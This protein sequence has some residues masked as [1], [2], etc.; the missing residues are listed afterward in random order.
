MART[1]K[2]PRKER[3]GRTV[4]HTWGEQAC[5]VREARQEGRRSE[6]VRRQRQLARQARKEKVE[7]K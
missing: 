3:E 5:L 7:E 6:E 4:L 1:K 2:T